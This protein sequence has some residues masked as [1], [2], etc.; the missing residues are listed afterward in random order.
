MTP[1]EIAEHFVQYHRWTDDF[2]VESDQYIL[3]QSYLALESRIAKL[4]SALTL[5]TEAL[6]KIWE[7]DDVCVAKVALD[8]IDDML[9]LNN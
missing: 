9:G 5:S 7:G 2:G 3:A 4:E 8:K 6:I 1:K